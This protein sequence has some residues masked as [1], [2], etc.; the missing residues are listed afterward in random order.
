VYALAFVGSLGLLP[1]LGWTASKVW[2]ESNV[3]G[4]DPGSV[5]EFY[6]LGVLVGWLGFAICS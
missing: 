5:Y 2:P 3:L 6:Y 1:L 4:K